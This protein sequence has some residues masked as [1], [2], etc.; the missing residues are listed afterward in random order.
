[1]GHFS[2]YEYIPPGRGRGLHGRAVQIV[3]RM[4]RRILWLDFLSN[5]VRFQRIFDALQAL[6]DEQRR[7]DGQACVRLAIQR[8]LDF[9]DQTIA[10]L[11]TP[12]STDQPLRSAKGSSPRAR[13][14]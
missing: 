7:L 5:E 2:Y 1:M 13:C 6:R 9:M 11:E 4:L 14:A 10:R 3:R 8:R 12:A